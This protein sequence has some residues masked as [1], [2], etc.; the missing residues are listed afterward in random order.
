M[1]RRSV[2][3]IVC[4]CSHAQPPVCGNRPSMTVRTASH[5]DVRSLTNRIT[6]ERLNAS[7]AEALRDYLSGGPVMHTGN[8]A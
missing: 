7:E 8:A 3:V 6:T 5:I 4:G 1:I 2:S